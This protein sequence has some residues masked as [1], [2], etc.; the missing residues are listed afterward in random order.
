MYYSPWSPTMLRLFCVSGA[1]FCWSLLI[2]HG[3]AA[4]PGS[5]SLPPPNNCTFLQVTVSTSP[6]DLAVT[7]PNDGVTCNHGDFVSNY[8]PTVT[9]TQSAAYGPNCSIFYNVNCNGTNTSFA[10]NVQQDFCSTMAGSI[11]SSFTMGSVT[12]TSTEGSFGSDTSGQV[13]AVLNCPTTSAVK[14]ATPE[15][16]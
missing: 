5:P 4:K 11:T 13:G 1:L 14:G 12:L 7:V 9:L 16:H 8:P 15:A 3:A 10:I 6:P 2:P